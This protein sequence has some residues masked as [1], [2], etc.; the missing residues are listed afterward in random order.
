MC[1]L[2]KIIHIPDVFACVYYNQLCPAIRMP[3]FIYFNEGTLMSELY[4]FGLI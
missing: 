2:M 3:V 4:V 1:L